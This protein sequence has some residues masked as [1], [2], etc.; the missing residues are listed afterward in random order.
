MRKWECDYVIVNRTSGNWKTIKYRGP[1]TEPGRGYRTHEDAM[2]ALHRVYAAWERRQPQA[3]RA[4]DLVIERRDR[5][6]RPQRARD[7]L[8]AEMPAG[9]DVYRLPEH[10]RSWTAGGLMSWWAI[11][12]ARHGGL[13]IPS[14]CGLRLGRSAARAMASLPALIANLRDLAR[15]AEVGAPEAPR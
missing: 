11:P 8:R 6:P 12:T 15:A 5:R 14:R 4:F 3:P 7:L 10:G 1:S 2:R 13:E 9:V